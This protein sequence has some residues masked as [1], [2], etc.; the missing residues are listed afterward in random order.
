MRG[1][2]QPGETEITATGAPKPGGPHFT[3]TPDG[4]SGQ[5]TEKEVCEPS[6]IISLKS[7]SKEN[8]ATESCSLIASVHPVV[9]TQFH[10]HACSSRRIYGH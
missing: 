7:A 1:N 3:T 10:L 6:I 9:F 5:R 2:T 8:F 4:G